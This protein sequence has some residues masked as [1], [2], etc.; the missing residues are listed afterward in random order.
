[1][2]KIEGIVKWFTPEKGFGF[3][4][5]KDMDNIF[6]HYSSIKSDGFKSLKKGQ[7]VYFRLGRDDRGNIAK[8]V[9]V[10]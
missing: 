4:K 1:M 10:K 3:I 5:S 8:D 7:K 6:V 9:E 2:K